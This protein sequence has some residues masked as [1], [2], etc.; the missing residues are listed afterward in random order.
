MYD[1]FISYAREESDAAETIRTALEGEGYKVFLDTQDLQAGKDYSEA[2]DDALRG[3]AAVV[4]VWS[5]QAISKR[6]VRGECRVALELEKLVPVSFEH[7]TSLDLP[8]EFQ[9]LHIVKLTKAG[10]EV[11]LRG[12]LSSVGDLVGRRRRDGVLA[13]AGVSGG[14]PPLRLYLSDAGASGE[15]IADIGRRLAASGIEV[16]PP[17]RNPHMMVDNEPSFYRGFDLGLLVEGAD[18]GKKLNG[19]ELER[20][21]LRD[22]LSV[23]VE[24]VDVRVSGYGANLMSLDLEDWSVNPEACAHRLVLMLRDWWSRELAKREY[25]RV[26]PDVQLLWRGPWWRKAAPAIYYDVAMGLER[27]GLSVRGYEPGSLMAPTFDSPMEGMRNAPKRPRIIFKG[28]DPRPTDLSAKM[29]A[30]LLDGHS[31]R[32]ATSSGWGRHA[33]FAVSILPGTRWPDW[34]DQQRAFELAPAPF[35]S[36]HGSPNWAKFVRAIQTKMRGARYRP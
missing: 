28:E 19:A 32:G 15:I 17:Q 23:C 18:I 29:S 12:L 8:A 5:K 21:E 2:I 14:G 24:P 33:D 13:A 27:A 20:R 6:W 34:V 10:N 9:G 22:S 25:W 7:L 3:S 35:M 36:I 11:A 30:W 1:V 16:T 26:L 4:G 31:M